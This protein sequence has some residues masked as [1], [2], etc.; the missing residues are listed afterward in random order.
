MAI[1]SKS[2]TIHLFDLA[3]LEEIIQANILKD[4]IQN[5]KYNQNKKH[6]L[7]SGSGNKLI[8]IDFYTLNKISEN[9]Y[10]LD[11]KLAD[12]DYITSFESIIL[13]SEKG[14][15]YLNNSDNSRQDKLL[16]IGKQAKYKIIAKESLIFLVSPFNS[17]QIFNLELKENKSGLR[18]VYNIVDNKLICFGITFSE[19]VEQTNKNRGKINFVCAFRNE[20]FSKGELNIY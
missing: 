20:N 18:N 17:L 1:G 8:C 3:I 15:L 5:I 10:N 11:S 19:N 14:T 4:R 16:E 13:I 7:C 2:G 12:Y 9:K 6:F